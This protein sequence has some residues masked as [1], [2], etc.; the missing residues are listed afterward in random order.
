[1]FG[2]HIVFLNL[3]GSKY[4]MRFRWFHFIVGNTSMNKHKAFI[5]FR[6]GFHSLIR[7]IL[8]K[9]FL[10]FIYPTVNTANS[11]SNIFRE[12]LIKIF[13]WILWTDTELPLWVAMWISEDYVSSGWCFVGG[14]SGGDCGRL[15]EEDSV[16]CA[17]WL[18]TR[19][20]DESGV[21]VLPLCDN[22]LTLMHPS[23]LQ[24]RSSGGERGWGC[25]RAPPVR[26]MEIL[27]LAPYRMLI[28]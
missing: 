5:L 18:T 21:K 12:A 14:G 1:M 16:S 17:C 23:S 28:V 20:Y 7:V 8:L 10:H 25:Q 6:C 27:S 2:C 4:A 13:T 11:P 19:D 22:L 15:D 24:P 26:L 3:Q 9:E